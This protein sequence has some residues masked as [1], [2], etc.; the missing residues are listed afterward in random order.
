VSSL[1]LQL[2]VGSGGPL[3][4]KLAVSIGKE[5]RIECSDLAAKEEASQKE[6]K[7]RK[8]E[9]HTSGVAVYHFLPNPPKVTSCGAPEVAVRKDSRQWTRKHERWHDSEV[10][11]KKMLIKCD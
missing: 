4:E 3:R 6:K 5:D 1:S 7:E 10:A 11:M 2:V 9:K 8:N